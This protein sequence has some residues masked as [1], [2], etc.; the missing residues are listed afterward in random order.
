MIANHFGT[1]AAFS[2]PNIRK[3]T[4]P[5]AAI[6]RRIK[7]IG[8]EASPWDE[9]PVIKLVWILFISLDQS[10][11]C[12]GWSFFYGAESFQQE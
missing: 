11:V 5:A 1:D 4:E 6:G 7:H 10:S 9:P 2:C 8:S 12:L 3:I